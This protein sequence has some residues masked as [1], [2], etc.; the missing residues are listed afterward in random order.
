VRHYSIYICIDQLIVFLVTFHYHMITSR[1]QH[2]GSIYYIH[3]IFYFMNC[4]VCRVYAEYN[5]YLSH[6]DNPDTY[7]S[8]KILS[9]T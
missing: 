8:V 5:F 7:E 3:V 6:F 9:L 2:S 1:W 4:A